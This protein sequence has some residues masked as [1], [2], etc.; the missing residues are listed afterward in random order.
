[1]L[2]FSPQINK[3][4]LLSQEASLTGSYLN[5]MREVILSSKTDMEDNEMA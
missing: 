5:S 3:Q 2:T 4:T 1:M